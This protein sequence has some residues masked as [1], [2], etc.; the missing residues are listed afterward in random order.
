MKGG[1]N[2]QKDNRAKQQHSFYQTC[3]FK[4]FLIRKYIFDHKTL[5]IFSDLWLF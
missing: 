1:L 2:T 4:G 3:N 5:Q